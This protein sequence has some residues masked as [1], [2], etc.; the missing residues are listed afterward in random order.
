MKEGEEEKESGAAC[1]VSQP[2]SSTL[3]SVPLQPAMYMY[4]CMYTNSSPPTRSNVHAHIHI[5]VHVHIHV[6]SRLRRHNVHAHIHIYVHVHIRTLLLVSGEEF[7]FEK[8]L[9]NRE[10]SVLKPLAYKR[11]TRSHP[12]DMRKVLRSSQ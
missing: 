4:M 12:L 5:Y 1:I 8:D 6:H 7:V 10:L 11:P 2:R 9:L 3:I